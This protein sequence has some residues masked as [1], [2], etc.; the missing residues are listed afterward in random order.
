M[1]ESMAA[2]ALSASTYTVRYYDDYLMDVKPIQLPTDRDLGVRKV[3]KK[4]RNQR[5]TANSAARKARR[6]HRNK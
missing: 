3:S 2:A 4:V 6:Q 1:F 5:R